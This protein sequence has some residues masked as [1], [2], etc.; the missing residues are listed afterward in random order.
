M[1]STLIASS[2]PRE[3]LIR[4][5]AADDLFGRFHHRLLRMVR[6]HVDQRLRDDAAKPPMSPAA[7]CKR[8]ITALKRPEA[9]L[10]GIPGFGERFWS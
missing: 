7:A 6:L 5:A 8:N 10:S 2:E 1:E 9:I 4:Q 3:T